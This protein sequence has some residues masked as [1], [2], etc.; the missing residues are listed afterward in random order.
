[1][2]L[3]MLLHAETSHRKKRPMTLCRD[4]PALAAATLLAHS[5]AW[6]A[7]PS[8]RWAAYSNT[9]IS[10]TGDVTFSPDRI[11]FGNGKSLPLAPAG[12]IPGYNALGR[13]VTASLFRVTAP[14][15]P[16]LLNGNRLCGGRT[17]QAVTFILVSAPEH[18]QGEPELRSMDVFAGAKPPN[19]QGGEI[20]CGTYNY[21]PAGAMPSPATTGRARPPNAR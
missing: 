21:E 12:T 19:A 20:S 6:A 1:M 4:L 3:P 8:E 16:L 13:S 9:A 15:D 5:F 2:Q 10:I 14:G 11:T 7:S 18:L 17:P